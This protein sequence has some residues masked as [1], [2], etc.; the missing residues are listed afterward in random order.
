MDKEIDYELEW[1][2]IKADIMDLEGLDE[3]D[4]DEEHNEDSVN[5][6]ADAQF[7]EEFGFSYVDYLDNSSN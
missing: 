5:R 7:E 3:E 2:R 4:M 1:L 6:E